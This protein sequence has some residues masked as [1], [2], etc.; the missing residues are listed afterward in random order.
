MGRGWIRI[1]VSRRTSNAK[2]AIASL[3][4]VNEEGDPFRNMAISASLSIRW[5]SRARLPNKTD[6][7]T[8]KRPEMPSRNASVARRVNASISAIKD[9]SAVSEC[10]NNKAK[11]AYSEDDIHSAMYVRTS[12]S[13][14]S[15]R[16]QSPQP[17][18]RCGADPAVGHERGNKMCRRD[19]E[20][21]VHRP[22]A[23]C[24][25]IDCGE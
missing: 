18:A 9:A 19:I 3:V 2:S 8:S 22:A 15:L 16:K 17:L 21:I 11:H 6:P 25:D 12:R 20:G 1:P 4:S 10:D 13:L 5:L 7:R 24:H 14:A 23:R